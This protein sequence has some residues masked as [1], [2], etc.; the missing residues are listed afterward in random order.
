MTMA[1]LVAYYIFDVPI[2]GSLVLLYGLSLLLM[3]GTLGIGTLVS[4]ASR[5]VPQAM[6]LA[7]GLHA[8]CRA[9]PEAVRLSP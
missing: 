5:T 8:G 1:L 6:P 9:L 7:G 2:R 4:A 3:G